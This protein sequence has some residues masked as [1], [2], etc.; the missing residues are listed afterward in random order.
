MKTKS[1]IRLA[2]LMIVPAV[3]VAPS[4]AHGDEVAVTESAAPKVDAVVYSPQAAAEKTQGGEKA[5]ASLASI[6]ARAAEQ[7]AKRQKS[8]TEWSADIAKAKGDCGQNAGAATRISSTQA[9]LSALATQIQSAADVATAKPLALQIYT[10][11]RVYLVVGPAVHIP[12]ACG[13]QSN[14]AARLLT[15]VANVQ[16]LIA[17]A[18]A[19]GADTAAATALVNSVAPLV[20]Q[21]KAASIAASNS[22]ASIVPDLGNEAI[23]TSNAATVQA[24]RDQIKAA[25]ALLDSAAKALKDARHSLSGAKKTDRE[26]DKADKSA[27]RSAKKAAA[28]EERA[29][30]KA[31]AEEERAAKK[32]QREANKADRK[33]KK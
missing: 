25:D 7:I 9:A 20:N 14:R 4:V 8:L 17:T 21:A 31:A 15:E 29:A 2:T 6:K 30:K 13:A 32:A 28:E 33:A 18:S 26:S 19:G 22:A 24:A 12:L 16:T 1:R 10:H 11:H 23:K 5:E 27:E 3:L